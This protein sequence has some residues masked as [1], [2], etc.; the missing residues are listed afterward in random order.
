MKF[1]VDQDQSGRGRF[2]PGEGQ[3]EQY[4]DERFSRQWDTQRPNGRED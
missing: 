2:V 4:N 1:F 3:A